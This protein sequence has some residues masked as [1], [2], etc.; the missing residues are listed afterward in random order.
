[1]GR[2]SS[3]I[4]TR[5][6]ANYAG[7]DLD[8][9]IE[10]TGYIPNYSSTYAGAKSLASVAEIGQAGAKLDYNQLALS[11]ETTLAKTD[12]LI[13]I[14][15]SVA[16]ASNEYSNAKAPSAK[17]LK[18]KKVPSG[19]SPVPLFETNSASNSNANNEDATSQESELLKL[20]TAPGFSSTYSSVSISPSPNSSSSA[21]SGS[22]TMLAQCVNVFVEP[23]NKIT[24]LD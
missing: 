13:S 9:L 22:N 17:K 18:T 2:N 21:S 15:N 4:A 19:P 3:R 12:D 24:D 5:R 7:D 23:T 16:T 11:T 10:A 14:I 6:I 8:Q 1:M 20:S